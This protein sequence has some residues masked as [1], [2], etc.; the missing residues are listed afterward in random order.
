MSRLSEISTQIRIFRMRQ[1]KHVW[2]YAQKYS[3][4]TKPYLLLNN[5]EHTHI[6]R[7]NY[8]TYLL[9]MAFVSPNLA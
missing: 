7:A 2:S 5:D 3:K 9:D 4:T 6:D 1:E 8:S